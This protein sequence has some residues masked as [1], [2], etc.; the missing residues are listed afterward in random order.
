MNIVRNK[1]QEI[2]A[3]IGTPKP[4]KFTKPDKLTN[5]PRTSWTI[6]RKH[7]R[8]TWGRLLKLFQYADCCWY[9]GKALEINGGHLNSATVDHI[10]PVHLGGGNEFCNLRLACAPCNS[11]RGHRDP[12]EFKGMRRAMGNCRFIG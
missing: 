5:E 6:H 11:A 9:C 4:A 2:V 8:R 7:N 1:N 3:F 12:D 10:R